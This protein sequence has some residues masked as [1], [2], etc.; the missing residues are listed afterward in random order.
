MYFPVFVDDD[1]ETYNNVVTMMLFPN[2]VGA[3]LEPLTWKSLRY[4]EMFKAK[5]PIEVSKFDSINEKRLASILNN[6]LCTSR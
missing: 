6:Y 2:G 3:L 4:V 5:I 1:E